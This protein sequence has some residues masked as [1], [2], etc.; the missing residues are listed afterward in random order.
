L[1][2]KLAEAGCSC[3]IAISI[4]LGVV[5]LN[6]SVVLTGKENEEQVAQFDATIEQAEKNIDSE[7]DDVPVPVAEEQNQDSKDNSL[8]KKIIL[9]G[10]D[11]L[12]TG[13]GKTANKMRALGIVG[14]VGISG[15]L[16]VYDVGIQISFTLELGGD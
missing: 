5:A 7:P 4:Q 6:L 1:S 8:M 9:S 16:T 13:L 10:V 11:K 15:L 2:K 3:E 14:K 12:I